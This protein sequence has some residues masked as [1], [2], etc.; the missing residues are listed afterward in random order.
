MRLRTERLSARVSRLGAEVLSTVG[1][2]FWPPGR[3][4]RC[5][6]SS[7]RRRDQVQSQPR[8]ESKAGR[9]MSRV[10]PCGQ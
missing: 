10:A 4:E 5:R 2:E 7:R 3:C 1:F 6:E 9:G 8:Q